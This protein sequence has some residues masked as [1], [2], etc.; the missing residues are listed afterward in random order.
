MNSQAESETFG[1]CQASTR[2]FPPAIE[3]LGYR[4]VRSTYIISLPLKLA[5]SSRW[6]EDLKT[7]ARTTSNENV[8][9]TGLLGFV[10]DAYFAYSVA[11]LE[12]WLRRLGI[13]QV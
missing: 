9:F 2:H 13:W 11:G 6:E 10:W 5:V 12:I 8:S 3:G 4:I 1:D 7:G